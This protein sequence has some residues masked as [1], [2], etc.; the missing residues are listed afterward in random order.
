MQKLKFLIYF[1]SLFSLT[2]A[3]VTG[4]ISGRIIDKESGEPLIGANIILQGALDRLQ[5][6]L[7]KD[8][9]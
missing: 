8:M 6:A 5:N 2:Q 7:K 4:K 9:V 3:G 1:F